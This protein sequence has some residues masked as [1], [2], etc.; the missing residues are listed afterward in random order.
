MSSDPNDFDI[1]KVMPSGVTIKKEALVRGSRD[2]TIVSTSQKTY[3][4]DN[5]PKLMLHFAPTME[6]EDGV[7][8]QK[9]YQY[10]CNVS[11]LTALKQG[12]GSSR[13]SAFWG[14]VIRLS[15]DPTV[16]YNGQRGGI[17]LTVIAVPEQSTTAGA[18]RPPQPPQPPRQPTAGAPSPIHRPAPRAHAAPWVG[19]D[20]DDPAF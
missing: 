20:G 11:A 5:R 16:E 1:D 2:F 4:G 17:K 3:E 14:G 18:P 15:Y 7:M 6:I 13:T 9:T 12:F 8:V 10:V 19:V